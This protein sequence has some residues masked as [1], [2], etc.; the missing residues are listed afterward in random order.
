MARLFLE[1]AG[2]A[3]DEASSGPEAL[4]RCRAEPYDIVILDH[5]MPGMTGI[6]VAQELTSEGY[7]GV[8]L[9]FSAYLH[10]E[11]EAEAERLGVTTIDK[12][13]Q[14]ELVEKVRTLSDA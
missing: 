13:R 4:D 11:V 12:S 7:A 9:L 2:F 5:R 8:L 10:P 6:E 3:L 1:E 14:E